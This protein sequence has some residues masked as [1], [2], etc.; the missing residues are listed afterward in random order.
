MPSRLVQTF[1]Q[2]IEQVWRQRAVGVE[3]LDPVVVLDAGL[4]RVDLAHPHDRSATAQ[5][6]HDQ[7]VR[8]G[9]VDAP[10]LVRG[11]PVEDD[12][13]VAVALLALHVVGGAGVDRRPVAHQLLAEGLHPGVILEELLATGDGAP[14]DVLVDVGVAGVVRHMLVFQA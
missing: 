1:L 14:R 12:L 2:V 6:E 8:V 5:G 4:L 13:G 11:D 7:V 9:A 3:A 10:L